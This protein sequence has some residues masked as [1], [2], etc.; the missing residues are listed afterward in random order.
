[1]RGKKTVVLCLILV[2]VGCVLAAIGYA[3]GGNTTVYIG[4]DGIEIIP[5]EK[6]VLLLEEPI[7]FAELY[8]DATTPDITI[9]EGDAFRLE[10]VYEDGNEAIYTLENGRL[11]VTEALQSGN[12]RISFGMFNI[13]RH[14]I[15]ITL[16]RGTTY[17]EI[18]VENRT[19]S[20]HVHDVKTKNLHIEGSTGDIQAK[21]IQADTAQLTTNTG[22]VALTNGAAQ[23]TTLENRVGS[24]HVKN[25]V[26]DTL[27]MQ[28]RTGSI[29]GDDIR[30]SEA[31]IESNT[32]DIS[33]TKWSSGNATVKN[34]TGSIALDGALSGICTLE[35]NV[36]DIRL[37][38]DR[39]REA[40]RTDFSTKT[41]S[42]YIHPDKEPSA[43]VA[44]T[45]LTARS[46]TGSI[47]AR[48]AE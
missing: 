29:H 21:N 25:W 40:Y 20:T 45:T 15:H 35:T 22:S 33:L 11:T 24:I 36:G 13:T 9:A 48:F 42:I 16:P 17:E 41:G 10:A 31:K 3:G 39:E 47:I 34:S 1:M 6:K 28:A 8:I 26:S 37:T 32:G 27:E 14:F 7:S 4:W 44:D 43:P 12:D 5:R 18:H 38:L 46:N 23:S 19:G 30:V 2:V